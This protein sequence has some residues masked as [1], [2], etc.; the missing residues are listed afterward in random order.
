MT[1]V[2]V[3]APHADDETL[4]CGGALLRHAGQG[5]RL[6]W[7]L[8]T[9]MTEEGGYSTAQR[10]ERDRIITAVRDHYGF[11]SLHRLGFPAARL[12]EVPKAAIVGALSQCFAA[13]G[14]QTLYLPFPGDAHDDHRLTFEAATAAAKW[15]RQPSIRRLY[16]YETPSETDQGMLPPS[17]AFIP[18]HFIDISA[19]LAGKLAALNLYH[20]ELK[21][22]PFPRSPDMVEYLS[23]VR[24]STCGCTA[25]EAFMVVREVVRP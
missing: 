6:H 18:N 12:D 25:A 3:V 10:H 15:F 16:A 14:A 23:H 9:D 5:D 19:H 11:A 8:V 7:V 13:T 1:D 24:G 21:P 20:T 4:G 17:G 2:L 22:F